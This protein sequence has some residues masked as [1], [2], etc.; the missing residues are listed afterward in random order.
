[1]S[2][3]EKPP[4]GVTVYPATI[5]TKSSIPPVTIRVR[6]A[7]RSVMTADLSVFTHER[8]VAGTHASI[9]IVEP[10]GHPDRYRIDVTIDD[11]WRPVG[12]ILKTEVAD[13]KMLSSSELGAE[14]GE[15]WADVIG[16]VQV[17]AFFDGADP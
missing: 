1:M 15:M 8:V 12:F 9:E 3:D 16:R 7:G 17:K 13:Q 11:V 10:I 6:A 4:K 5:K 2:E 14:V